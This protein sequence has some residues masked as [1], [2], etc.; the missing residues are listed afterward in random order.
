MRIFKRKKQK[1]TPMKDELPRRHGDPGIRRIALK[2]N[3]YTLA[4]A[5]LPGYALAVMDD[6]DAPADGRWTQAIRECVADRIQQRMEAVM[7]GLTSKIVGRRAYSPA[8]LQAMNCNLVGGYPYS[9]ICSPDPFF[10]L[11]PFAGVKGR[12]SH[13][14]PYLNLLGLTQTRMRERQCHRAKRLAQTFFA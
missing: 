7:P 6:T 8:D 4:L 3:D 9:G 2:V 14:T 5:L 11:R 12:R 10:G 1:E 13:E